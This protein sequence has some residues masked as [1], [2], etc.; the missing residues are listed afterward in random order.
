MSVALEYDFDFVVVSRGKRD[1]QLGPLTDL[2][3][4]IY[5]AKAQSCLVRA[6]SIV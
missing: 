5:W 6:N 2:K 1:R 3:L 4:K